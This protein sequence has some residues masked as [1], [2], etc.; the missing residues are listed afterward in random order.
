MRVVR[1]V[2]GRPS[3]VRVR[4]QRSEGRPRRNT[5]LQKHQVRVRVEASVILCSASGCQPGLNQLVFSVCKYQKKNRILYI[6]IYNIIKYITKFG[7]TK[8][9][10]ALDLVVCAAPQPENMLC[11]ACGV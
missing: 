5:D 10:G 9:T 8:T 3:S 7:F 1:Y 4:G 11:A 6:Y 2:R